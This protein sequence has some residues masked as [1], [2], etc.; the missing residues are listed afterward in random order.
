MA[1]VA[2]ADETKLS[3]SRAGFVLSDGKGDPNIIFGLRNG[4]LAISGMN[5]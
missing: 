4:K 2:G 3:P 5:D 1:S